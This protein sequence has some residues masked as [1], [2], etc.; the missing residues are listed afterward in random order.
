MKPVRLARAEDIDPLG[1]ALARA[2]EHDPMHRWIFPARSDWA[3]N[4]HRSFSLA[5]RQGM[6]RGVVLT[7]D[8]CRGAAIW[9]DSARSPA[10]WQELSFAIRML[11]L[12]G[13]RALSVGRAFGQLEALH[14]GPPHW[15]LYA[16][17][18][19]PAHQGKGVGAAL[20]EPLLERCDAES[21]GA[22]LEASRPENVPYYR[23]FGF[24]VTGEF[25]L[26]R[27]PVVWR[28]L[29]EPRSRGQ[30]CPGT[31]RKLIQQPDEGSGLAGIRRAPC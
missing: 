14:P 19:D 9:H 17:G 15:Y 27:G 25:V 21:R 13:M 1:R 30:G 7:D 29:R 2:F 26:P 18:T 6:S 3:R 20:L 24:E 11:P 16:V 22:Y 8:A 31:A 10:F 23:R 4:S 28:M 12:L 5:I